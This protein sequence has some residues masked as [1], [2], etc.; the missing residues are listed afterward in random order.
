MERDIKGMEELRESLQDHKKKISILEVESTVLKNEKAAMVEDNIKVEEILLEHQ[1]KKAGQKKEMIRL[2]D[3]N[4]KLHKEKEH[5][6]KMLEEE[7]KKKRKARQDLK[8][9]ESKKRKLKRKWDA[10]VNEADL[11]KKKSSEVESD[12]DRFTVAVDKERKKAKQERVAM[13]QRI[14]S[15]ESAE[16]E[17][18]KKEAIDQNDVADEVDVYETILENSLKMSMDFVIARAKHEVTQ[19]TK[20]LGGGC[21]KND[22]NGNSIDEEFDYSLLDSSTDEPK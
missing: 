20:D 3:G 21:I 7:K 1:N 14:T 22:Q 10:A 11:M 2:K 18:I 15:L 12:L 13:L 19:A 6:E 8:D 4:T 17:L 9:E 16:D 5:I